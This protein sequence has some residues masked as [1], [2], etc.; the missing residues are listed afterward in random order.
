MSVFGEL[1]QAF[2]EAVDN[3]RAELDRDRVP[4]TVDELLRGM[5]REVVDARTYALRLEEDIRK[6]LH[7]AESEGEEAST[8]RRREKMALEIGDE[9]TAEVAR[10]FAERHEERKRVLERKALALREELELRREEIREMLERLHEART[11]RDGL[12]ASA[13]RTRAREVLGDADA[14]F[15]ELDRMEERIGDTERRIRAEEEL[16]EDL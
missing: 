16:E 12:G 4:E 11:L 15:E 5:R 9:E 8:C 2:R 7:R 10:D 6:A 1:A 14:L 13:G 3:F